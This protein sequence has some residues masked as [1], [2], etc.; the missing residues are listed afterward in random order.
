MA[1]KRKQ[2]VVMVSSTVYGIEEL[3][4]RVYAILVNFGYEVWMSHKETLPVFPDKTAFENC[5]QAV[6]LHRLNIENDLHPMYLNGR[7]EG[8]C[9][10]WKIY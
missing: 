9:R 8:I 3:L 7:L 6:R 2:L 10:G 5:L 1:A 4:E